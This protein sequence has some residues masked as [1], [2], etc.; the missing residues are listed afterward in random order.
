MNR[1]NENCKF[2]DKNF[3]ITS[4][5]KIYKRGPSGLH[6]HSYHTDQKG[7]KGPSENP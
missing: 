6:E 1:N 5:L 7:E 2:S 4:E 3:F